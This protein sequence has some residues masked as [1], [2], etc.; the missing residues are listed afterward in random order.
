[1]EP[2]GFIIFIF[3]DVLLAPCPIPKLEDHTLLFVS[4]YLFIV[5][6][7]TLHSWKPS[8]LHLQFQDVPCCGD[9]DL[10]NIDLP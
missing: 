8:L 3:Y 5:F 2:E 1:M 10:P 6:T 7:V 9:M 4:D